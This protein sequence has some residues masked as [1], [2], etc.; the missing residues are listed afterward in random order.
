V[1][2]EIMNIIPIIE[3]GLE[4]VDL[5]AVIAIDEQ[6]L[7]CRR[8]YK[9]EIGKL[10]S[11]MRKAIP[12][13]EY[14]G[15]YLAAR[16]YFGNKNSRNLTRWRLKYEQQF[17]NI[18]TLGNNIE[19]NDLTV[20]HKNVITNNPNENNNLPENN[21]EKTVTYTADDLEPSVKED[22]FRMIK[23]DQEEGLK[24]WNE[25]GIKP[26]LRWCRAM[27]TEH[28]SIKKEQ[29]AQA[30]LTV[31]SSDVEVPKGLNIKPMSTAAEQ[32]VID[33]YKKAI[34]KEMEKS[35]ADS[36]AANCNKIIDSYFK[37][38]RE[39]LDTQIAYIKKWHAEY[40]D[41]ERVGFRRITVAEF[42][43]A[44]MEIHPDKH[45]EAT[46]ENKAKLAHAFQIFNKLDGIWD[47]YGKDGKLI[48]I[49]W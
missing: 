18:N 4:V 10:L 3:M 22:F 5:G 25:Q 36:V 49:D 46:P 39:E 44:R 26:T 28:G 14:F 38:E 20:K 12:S 40:S 1:K 48:Q 29:K 9:M 8:G 37:A 17:P 2:Q 41:R 27:I 13:D 23:S 33:K 34:F 45:P 16:K 21:E 15:K 43:V 31:K 11:A 6:L 30:K 19:N 42:K 7:Q 24:R 47:Q 35:Y 32:R